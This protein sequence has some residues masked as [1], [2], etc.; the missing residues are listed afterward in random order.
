MDQHKFIVIQILVEAMKE[1][2]SQIE[3]LESIIY[4]Q[5]DNI[6]YL[7]EQV[8]GYSK[9]NG[10]IKSITMDDNNKDL[11]NA[12]LYQ[13][14]P[15][16]FSVNTEIKFEIPENANSARLIIH[17]MQGAEIK[18][19]NIT[20]KGAG[21]IIIQGAELQAGMYMYTLLIDNTIVDTKRMILTK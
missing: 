7:Q 11:E 16:P 2:Q 21:N 9:G 17:D 19:Y 12:K 6:N 4:K 15:N 10:A 14:T 1:Q 18:S 13:N 20:A 8:D 3:Q 5:A